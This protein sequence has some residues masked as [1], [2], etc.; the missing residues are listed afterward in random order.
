MPVHASKSN[1]ND[2]GKHQ[3]ITLKIQRDYDNSDYARNL[4]SDDLIFARRTQWNDELDANVGT[5]YR[6]QFDIVKPERRRILAALVKNE[7]SNKYRAKNKEDEKLAEVLQNLYRATVRTNDAKFAAEVAISEAIDCGFGAWRIEVVEEDDE[8]PINTNKK[9]IRSVIHEANNKVIWDSNSKKI[10]KSDAIDCTIITSYTKDSWKELMEEYDLDESES[11]FALP[12]YTRNVSLNWAGCDE[13]TVAEYYRIKERKQKMTILSD[14]KD[15]IALTTSEYK[16]QVEEL[17]KYG[18]EKKATKTVIKRDV[19][20]T[21]L[22][23]A[24]IL[25][26]KKIAGKHIPIVPVYGE[27]SIN[28]SSELW[29]G[30]VRCLRDAQQ[31][32]NTTMSY[33]FDLLAKGPIAKDIYTP[34]QIHGHEAMYE[35]QNQHKYPYYLLNLKD[36]FDPQGEPLPLGPIGQRGGPDVP[37]A[38]MAILSLADQAVQQSVGGGMS[39]EQMINP[40]VTDDQL[41]IIQAHLDVQS[42]LYKEH[43]EYAYRREG[44]ICA[45]IWSQIIDTPRKLGITKVDGT[46]DTVEVNT[47]STNLET[48]EMAIDIDMSNAD[49]DVYTDVGMSFMDQKDKNRTEMLALMDKPLDPEL[50]QIVMSTYILNLDGTSYE[51][52]RKKARKD[53][54]MSGSVEEGDLTDEEKEMLQQA[55]QQEAPPDPMMIAAQAAQTEADAKMIGEETDKKKA[56]ID[57]FRA[58]TDRMALQLKAQELG[59]KL[60]ESEANTRNKDASTNKIFR[61]IQ[62]KDV[63]DMVKVQDSISKGRDSYTKMSASQ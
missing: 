6:G 1:D 7:F 40:Q 60:K 42:Q 58:E 20:K 26:R 8:D 32:K 21:I 25:E 35:E 44:Q 47:V 16:D 18:F 15:V 51:P 24:S 11:D 39:P 2:S 43:L 19:W 13:Y 50:H 27:W 9:L 56:E 34:E 37:P 48:L 38:A 52:L 10:D 61:D 12:D 3:E 4:G 23:G 45:S 22:T 46:E 5:E 55:A 49:M 54:V 41:K 57:M 17:E 62:S 14:G 53:M 29:E 28:G 59:I 30:L 31:I 36:P 33:I 63:E